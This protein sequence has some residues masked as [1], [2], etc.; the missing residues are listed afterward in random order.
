[1]NAWTRR[2][3]SALDIREY[4]VLWLGTTPRQDEI[5]IRS[6]VISYAIPYTTTIA[7]AQATV[8]GLEVMAKKALKVASLQQYHKK[9][10]SKKRDARTTRSR[11]H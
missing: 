10:G 9:I 4:R 5:K 3:F 6:Q 7:G 2:T 1:M 8:N 11:N